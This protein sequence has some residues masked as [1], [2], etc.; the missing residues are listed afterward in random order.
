MIVSF[1]L[2][3]TLFVS[4]KA[5]R[6]EPPLP[7]PLRLLYRERLRA[8][9]VA[10]LRRLRE[11]GH[12]VWIYTTSYRSER[13]IRG[14]FRC[15]G[16]RLDRVIN[17]ETHQNEVQAGRAEGMPSKYP[18]KYRIGLHV[19]D[20]VSVWENGKVYGFRVFLVGAQ[21][22]GWADKIL[23][24]IERIGTIGPRAPLDD[25]RKK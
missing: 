8:G 13:Y 14:L 1:D 22:D 3:D 11:Q 17:G 12:Q 21:D 23:S 20:D 15:Y 16:I 6:T 19:D 10:L 4:E 24:E 2:D 25:R 9:T 5:F 18:S 7:L